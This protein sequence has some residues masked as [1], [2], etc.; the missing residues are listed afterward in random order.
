M[1]QRGVHLVLRS[2]LFFSSQLLLPCVKISLPIIC[3]FTLLRHSLLL[4]VSKVLGAIHLHA[5]SQS[6]L[7]RYRRSNHLTQLQ[8]LLP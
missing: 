7:E 6:D 2:S 5:A 8:V 1:Q 4:W 3:T